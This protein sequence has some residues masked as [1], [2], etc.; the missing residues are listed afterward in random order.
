MLWLRSVIFN[1]FFNIWTF[2][3][4]AIFYPLTF[5]DYRLNSI[6]GRVWARGV[7]WGLKYIT[8]INI[9]I[10]GRENLPKDGNYVI[11][12][13]HQSAIDTA[14]FLVESYAP[15]YIFKKE[16]L[17]IPLFGRHLLKM[18]MISVDRQGGS[19]AIKKMIKDV[20]DRLKLGQ[21]VVIFP[22]GTRVMLGKVVKYQPGIALIYKEIDVPIIPVALNSGKF[23]P[24]EPKLKY[25]GT[26][27]VQYLPAIE[28]GLPRE[29]FMQKLENTIEKA[30]EKL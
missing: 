18:N 9:E 17:K 16:L 21:N 3:Q 4:C 1:I 26:I 2:L 14:I 22:E 7:F 6:S 10:I 12:A 20:K 13:K 8:K 24:R 15:V 30:C 29:E 11:A 27:I 28:L 25:P 23:W 19:S 5:A